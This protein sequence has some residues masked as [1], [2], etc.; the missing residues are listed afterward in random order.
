MCF[1]SDIPIC[2]DCLKFHMKYVIS[3]KRPPLPISIICLFKVL[4]WDSLLKKIY[5]KELLIGY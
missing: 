3:S 2:Q 4:Y 5:K 1:H